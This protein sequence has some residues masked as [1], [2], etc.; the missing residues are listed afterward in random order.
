MWGKGE[1]EC[2]AAR[3]VRGNQL[4]QL[5]GPMQE[6]ERVDWAAGRGWAVLFWVWATGLGWGFPFLFLFLLPFSFLILVQTKLNQMNSNLN[7]NS[8]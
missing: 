1:G 4:G 7:L 6:K 2:W 5:A 8:L 3:G